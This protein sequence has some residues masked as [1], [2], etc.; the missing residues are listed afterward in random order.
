MKWLNVTQGSE[1]WVTA[2]LGIPTAS[3][4]DRILTPKTRKPS[5]SQRRYLCELLA[6][7]VTRNQVVDAGSAWMERGSTLEREAVA[8]YELETGRKTEPCGLAL[9][10][11]ER[12]GASPDRTIGLSG[13]LEIKCPAAHTHIGYLLYGLDAEYR[14]Q[15]QGQL[16][17]TGRA[18]VDFLSHCPGFPPYLAHTEPEG[19]VQAALTKAL[20]EFCAEL[21][22][23]ERRLQ[24]LMTTGRA[25]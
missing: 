5:A 19:E 7:R 13:L 25:A 11:D 17:V 16:W 8:F 14:I 1:E 2:R 4:F 21:D 12:A 15:Q 6:E 3:A 9:T 22:R 10:N 20:P 23:C 24:D 18:F